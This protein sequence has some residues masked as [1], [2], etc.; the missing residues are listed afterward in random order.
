M[1]IKIQLPNPD[2]YQY[3]GGTKDWFAQLGISIKAAEKTYLQ[4]TKDLTEEDEKDEPLY[5]VE[6]GVPYQMED[7]ILEEAKE[8]GSLRSPLIKNLCLR[9]WSL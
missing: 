2:D 1:D 4:A 6:I 7:K 8:E 3:H 5:M 9:V